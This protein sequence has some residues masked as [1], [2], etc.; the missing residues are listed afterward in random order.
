MT[1]RI[2][3]LI[4]RSASQRSRDANKAASRTVLK[5]LSTFEPG[6]PDDYRFLFSAVHLFAVGLTA[7]SMFASGRSVPLARTSDGA[8]V[9]IIWSRDCTEDEC[10]SGQNSD[11]PM[12]ITSHSLGMGSSNLLM[13][14]QT[15][16]G[17]PFSYFHLRY[18]SRSCTDNKRSVDSV[19]IVSDVF[20]IRLDCYFTP[21]NLDHQSTG[22]SSELI[23]KLANITLKK[24]LFRDSNE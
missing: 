4:R 17:L 3:G 15:D 11:R 12:L 14:I 6:L 2:E 8:S 7:G 24:G 10:W 18:R 16:D 21:V 19:S 5:E 13:T 1:R 9:G 22:I 20:R 23:S